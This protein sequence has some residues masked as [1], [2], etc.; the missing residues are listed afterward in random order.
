M[1]NWEILSGAASAD[2]VDVVAV[3][4][5]EPAR[6]LAD[7]IAGTAPVLLGGEDALGQARTI[8]ALHR[9]AEVGASVS[10]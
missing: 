9:A 5:R 3:A 10:L 4:S 1:I 6:G 2:R 8:D 7:A